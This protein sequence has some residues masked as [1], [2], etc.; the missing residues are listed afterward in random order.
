DAVLAG[1]GEVIGVLP[2]FLAQKKIAHAGLSRFIAVETMHERKQM[3]ADMADAFIALP[4][5]YGTLEELAEV[6]TWAQLGLHGK[7][8]GLLNVNGFYDPLLALFDRMAQD[9]FMRPS[10]RELLLCSAQPDALL[11]QLRRF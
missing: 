1:G 3:M 10:H 11:E 9:G 5:G 2:R 4:G 6:L 8:V 7:P